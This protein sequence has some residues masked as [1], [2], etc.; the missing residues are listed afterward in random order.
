MFPWA[1][2][3][4]PAPFRIRGVLI[5]AD[6]LAMVAICFAHLAGWTVVGLA[7]G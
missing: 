5:E 6:S 7:A 4:A 1:L 3:H 2:V